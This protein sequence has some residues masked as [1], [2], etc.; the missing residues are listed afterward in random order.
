MVLH[1][2]TST[3]GDLSFLYC[4]SLRLIEEAKQIGR[5]VGSGVDK[6]MLKRIMAASEN[7]PNTA[8]HQANP[9]P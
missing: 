5:G 7:R 9:R 6:I 1:F 4:S 8:H 2:K 3:D